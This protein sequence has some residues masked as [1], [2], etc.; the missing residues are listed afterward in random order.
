M[1]ENEAIKEMKYYSEEEYGKGVVADMLEI[2]RKGG[3][4]E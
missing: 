1:T 3:V 4:D 2:V